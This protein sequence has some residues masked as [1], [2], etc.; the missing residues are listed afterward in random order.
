MQ[1]GREAFHLVIEFHH[2]RP[3]SATWSLYLAMVS[4]WSVC[5]SSQPWSLGPARLTPR[6]QCP[7]T[8]LKP[9]DGGVT[10]LPRLPE[11]LS[12]RGGQRGSQIFKVLYSFP[13]YSLPFLLND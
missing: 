5:S 9:E 8:P 6:K 4:F 2:P 10:A 13:L 12:L 11:S 3:A 1:N 7:D